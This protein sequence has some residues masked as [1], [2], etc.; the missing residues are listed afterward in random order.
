M[1]SNY[2]N[3]I[4]LLQPILLWSI[5]S[6]VPSGKFLKLFRIGCQAESANLIGQ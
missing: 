4:D 2:Q 6:Q 5:L 1:D 3:Q